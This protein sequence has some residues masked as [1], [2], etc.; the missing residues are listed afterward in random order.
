MT[1]APRGGF[2]LLLNWEAIPECFCLGFRCYCCHSRTLRIANSS[3][4]TTTELFGVVVLFLVQQVPVLP[5]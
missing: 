5:L 4:M 2:L 1:P 3:G